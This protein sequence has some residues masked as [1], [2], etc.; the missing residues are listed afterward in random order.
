VTTPA[1]FPGVTLRV[2]V[3]PRSSRNSMRV[4]P[5]G[6][7]C[8]SLTAPPLDGEANAALCSFLANELDIPRRAV[9]ILRGAKSRDKTVVFDASSEKLRR[10]EE[11]MGAPGVD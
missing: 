5:D 3:Q 4:S 8:V 7:L 10:L 9:R 1:K 2:R 11:Q 6:R